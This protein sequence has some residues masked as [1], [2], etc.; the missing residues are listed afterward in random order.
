MQQSTQTGLLQKV[1][2]AIFQLGP[3][4]QK[5]L[6]RRPLS[7][8]LAL[9]LPE[10]CVKQSPAHLH[11]LYCLRTEHA[12]V[13]SRPFIA[14]AKS[15]GVLP[16]LEMTSLAIR[17]LPFSHSFYIHK[18]TTLHAAKLPCNVVY[19]CRVHADTV[20]PEHHYTMLLPF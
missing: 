3:H 12:W 10:I 4:E 8:R 13:V 5:G 14:A 2:A 16:P 18:T 20:K 19:V 9:S 11:L 6:R 7:A 1:G 15:S 17:S